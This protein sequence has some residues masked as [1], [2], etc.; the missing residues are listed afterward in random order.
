MAPANNTRPTKEISTNDVRGGITGN[1][2]R[3]VLWISLV[4]AVIALVAVYWFF[5][6]YH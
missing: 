2:V 5:Y 4:G 6:V 1:G 3:Y